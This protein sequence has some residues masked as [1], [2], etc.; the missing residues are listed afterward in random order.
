MSDKQNTINR[1]DFDKSVFSSKNTFQDANK[2]D[3][4]IKMSDIDEVS[5]TNV[6][7]KKQLRGYNSFVAPEEYYEFQID[8]MFLVIYK[9]KN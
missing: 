5:K 1:I 9:I 6:D 7:E 4:T 2:T 8:L 3:K